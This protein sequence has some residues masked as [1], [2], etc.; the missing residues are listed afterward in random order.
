MK[1]DIIIIG[2]GGHAKVVA[3]IIAS[4]GFLYICRDWPCIFR[5]CERGV[6][7]IGDND[8]REMVVDA[9]RRKYPGFGFMP[10]VHPRATIASSAEIGQGTVIMA[11]VVIGPGCVIGE[12]CI[13]NTR[14]SLDH[15]SEMGDFSSLAPGATIGGNVSIGES[16]AICIGAS[17]AHGIKIGMETII[18]AGS[19]VL[20]D[21][22]SY[23]V[24]YG[25]PAREQRG[26]EAGDKYL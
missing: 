26:R 23:V 8:V 13:L 4:D 1:I 11:G 2:S 21:I 25:T 3:D 19:T 17:V 10:A 15:D 5:D 18:G 14:S 22:D 16:S 20:R 24:A 6:V 12:H 9:I 7:G